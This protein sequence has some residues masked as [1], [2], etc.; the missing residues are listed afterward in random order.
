MAPCYFASIVTIQRKICD[1]H[2]DYT[3]NRLKNWPTTAVATK[4]LENIIF[5]ALDINN[6]NPHKATSILRHIIRNNLSVNSMFNYRMD[7]LTTIVP[8]QWNFSV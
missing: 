8:D 4:Y 6:L 7:S 1:F 3:F 2:K 5:L